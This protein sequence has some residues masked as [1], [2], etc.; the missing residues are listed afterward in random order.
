VRFNEGF[1]QTSFTIACNFF[2][3][4]YLNYPLY[5]IVCSLSMKEERI[6]QWIEFT[7]TITSKTTAKEVW[8]KI[9]KLSGKRKSQNIKRIVKNDGKQIITESGIVN[10]LAAHFAKTSSTEN[11][12]TNFKK[13]KETAEKAVITINMENSNPYYG[14]LTEEELETA[15]H[16]C[17]GS[18]PGPDDIHCEV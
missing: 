6:T 3:F 13:K 12:P 14:P 9:E 10:E 1:Y 7:Q 5:F 8:G 18:S 4:F 16:D 11:Y 2:F 15:L 17:K